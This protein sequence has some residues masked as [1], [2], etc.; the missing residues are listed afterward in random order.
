[1]SHA[2]A[3]PRDRRRAAT[4]TGPIIGA[5]AVAGIVV[6]IMQTLVVPLVADLPEL[7][8]ASASNTAWVV[9]AALLGAAVSTPILGRL[10]DMYG[11]K[12]MML[13]SL[14]ILT[15]GSVLGAL[16]SSLLVVIAARTLQG[17]SLGL[18]PLGISVMRDELP[19][20]KL[21]SALGLMSSSLGIGGALG[22]PLAAVIAQQFNWHV[23][24]WGAAG[25][26][27][28]TLALVWRVIPESP[29]RDTGHGRFDFV[30]AAGLS[31]GVL[32][33]L[34]VISKGSDW[35]WLTGR[36]LGVAA[37]GVVVLAAWGAWE[38]R[39]PSP[40]VDLR[41]SARRQV[42]MTNLTSV[43][44]G[45]AMYGVS[46]VI[47]QLM[48]APTG[49]GYGFGQSMVVA[50]LCFAPF[51]VVMMLASPFTARVSSA[52]GPKTS[53]MLGAL[54]IGVSYGLG[55]VLIH[56][57]WQ[58]ILVSSLVGLGIALAYSA[59]PAL[60]MSAVPP[61]ETA[62]ANGL[63]TLMRSIGTSS[64]AAVVG[65]VLAHMTTTYQ[66]SAVPSLAGFK[67]TF[68]IGAAAAAVALVLAAFIP[69]RRASAPVVIPPQRDTALTSAENTAPADAVSP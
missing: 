12:R 58:I 22:V 11:K 43:A 8:D 29:V 44:I 26:G 60:I 13:I 14:G 9:T 42:L 47:P 6:S 18:V 3:E 45:F 63:N 66:G 35:G 55:V 33:L 27:L 41:I 68:I 65:V 30:G 28:L 62:A 50:G 59:M 19:P 52:F 36:T 23:L 24:F 7:L 2:S 56:H 67:T 46:L 51:G 61:T 25:L 69:G 16:T 34:L 64:S 48:Q 4:A 10:G 49:T 20:E 31:I 53:L 57:I 21:G 39:S 37:V 40:L 54:T 1:M 15:I 17:L 32:A 38:L 5:L